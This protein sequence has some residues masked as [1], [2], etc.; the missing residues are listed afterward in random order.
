[1]SVPGEMG[2]SG[3]PAL[4]L[5]AEEDGATYLRTRH[6]K[7]KPVRDI[8]AVRGPGYCYGRGKNQK[9]PGARP[10]K[11]TRE[12]TVVEA[13]RPANLQRQRQRADTRGPQKPDGEEDDG[14]RSGDEDHMAN[15]DP[16][17]KPLAEESPDMD[18]EKRERR[19]RLAVRRHFAEDL[20]KLRGRAR[21]AKGGALEFWRS[22][23]EC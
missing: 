18:N 9:G 21:D 16:V 11:A 7:L 6:R 10:L 19:V 1:M 20:K 4:V 23:F 13:L 5:D 15:H 17:C 8:D 14:K 12:A 22:A 3:S 2:I